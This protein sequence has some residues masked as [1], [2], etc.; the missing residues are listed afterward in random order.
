[1]LSLAIHKDIIPV[2]DQKKFKDNYNLKLTVQPY[3]GHILILYLNFQYLQVFF[4]MLLGPSLLMC[5]LNF[6]SNY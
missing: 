2:L 3:L 6:T 5:M 4:S 1:M